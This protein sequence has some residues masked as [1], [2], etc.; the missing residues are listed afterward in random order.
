MMDY[1]TNLPDQHLFDAFMLGLL[2][3]VKAFQRH[4]VRGC[5]QDS[6]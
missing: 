4:D 1:A 2:R 3:V 5:S 6:Q